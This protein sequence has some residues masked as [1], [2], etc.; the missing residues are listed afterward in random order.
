MQNKIL[1][2]AGDPNSINSEIIFKSWN[3]L[4]KSIKNKIIIIGNLR[5]LKMQSKKIKFK[6]NLHNIDNFNGPCL[7]NYLNIIDV[8]LKFKDCFKV[9]AIESSQYVISCLS[10]AHKL[11]IKKKLVGFINCS[12]DKKLINKK[13]IYGVTE[14]VAK[15]SK[16]KKSSEVMMLYNKNLAVVPITT[17]IKIKEV[18]KKINKKIIVKKINTLTKYY[19]KLFKKKPKIGVLGLNPH[20]AEYAHN[21]EEVREIIPAINFLKKKVNIKGPFS[22]D[23]FFIK[24]YKNYNVIVGMYHDQILIPFKN[25]YKYDAINVTLGLKYTRVSPDHGTGIALIG[26][27]KANTESLR[28]CVNFIDNL[29]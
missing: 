15:L 24:D 7:N 26:K 27:N 8:P 20:N 16:V 19:F 4:K 11:S 5:L 10:L 25:F 29:K 17:H 12:I 14:L 9:N 2:V 22:S 28:Q 1:I 3:N 21:S 18:S 6:I 23:S 13:G